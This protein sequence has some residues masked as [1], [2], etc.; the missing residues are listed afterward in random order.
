C[1]I[2][3]LHPPLQS[4]LPNPLPSFT[5]QRPEV[6]REMIDSRATI[7]T[8]TERQRQRA[9]INQGSRLEHLEKS[10]SYKE[11]HSLLLTCLSSRLWIPAGPFG[12]T[13]GLVFGVQVVGGSSS[14]VRNQYEMTEGRRGFSPEDRETF[15]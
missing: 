1:D 8:Q 14:S 3:E 7:W 10:D 2:T 6:A 11:I 12:T 13:G 15:L 9:I 5:P 4:P